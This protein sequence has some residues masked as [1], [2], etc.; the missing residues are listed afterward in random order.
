MRQLLDALRQADVTVVENAPRAVLALRSAGECGELAALK[1]ERA[2]TL[3]LPRADL[4][5]VQEALGQAGALQSVG[6]AKEALERLAPLEAKAAALGDRG[7]SAAVLL[8]HAEIQ[9]DLGAL[10]DAEALMHRAATEATAA[11]DDAALA[12]AWTAL[13]DEVGITRRLPRE[14]ERWSG[15]AQAAVARLDSPIELAAPLVCTLG[16]IHTHVGK[17]DLGQEELRRC[18]DLQQRLNGPESLAVAEAL[19]A[20]AG[21]LI[22][23]GKTHEAVDAARRA[24]EL[25]RRLVGPAH[26]S[27]A[28]LENHLASVLYTIGRYDEALPLYEESLAVME[29]AVGKDSARLPLFLDNLANVYSSLGRFDDAQRLL[30]RALELDI[31]AAGP[32]SSVVAQIENNIAATYQDA[33]DLQRAHEHFQRSLEVSERIEG[34][35][36]ARLAQALSGL[37]Q[38]ALGLGHAEES[39]RDCARALELLKGVPRAVPEA[40]TCLGRAELELGRLAP[41]VTHLEAAVAQLEERGDAPVNLA[42]PRFALARALW[43]VSAERARAVGL[44]RQAREAFGGSPSGRAAD[45]DAWLKA[46]PVGP[47]R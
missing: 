23:S 37:G 40:L 4:D 44:A 12:R 35:T 13:T 32:E 43:P 47:H 41:A 16:R 29:R 28:T 7:L 17:L 2:R 5:Q 27:A 1:S 20:Q 24:F 22:E 36:S 10:D 21:A 38:T 34:P 26:P 39:A 25:A 30:A 46:H 45:V 14:A 19:S 42:E 18:F 15:Y 11:R 31:R 33:G 8:R 9:R 3:A 6:K